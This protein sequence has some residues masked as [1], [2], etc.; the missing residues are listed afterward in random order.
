MC[1]SFPPFWVEENGFEASKPLVSI[2][3]G[4]TPP[5][6]AGAKAGMGFTF[7]PPRAFRGGLLFIMAA[8]NID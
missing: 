7:Q 6:I 2:G 1:G 3:R 5:F 4:V 8:A